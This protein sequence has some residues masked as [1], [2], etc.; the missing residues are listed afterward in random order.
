MTAP[1]DIDPQ[2]TYQ[3]VY[4]RLVDL[5]E[6]EDEFPDDAHRCV[7]EAFNMLTEVNLDHPGRLPDRYYGPVPDVVQQVRR[8]LPGLITE[9]PDLGT[10]VAL[11][12]V[13]ACLEAALA[14]RS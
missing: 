8:L 10:A 4:A 2:R 5:C 6:R 13:D 3:D 9:S 12:R 1:V 11:L 14:L 7:M